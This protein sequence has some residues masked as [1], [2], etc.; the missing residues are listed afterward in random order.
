MGTASHTPVVREHHDHLQ[1]ADSS[2][3]LQR[4]NA[5]SQPLYDGSFC[6][7]ASSA[8]RHTPCECVLVY[9]TPHGRASFTHQDE[10]ERL[11]NRLI[12]VAQ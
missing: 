4:V 9:V 11:K 5:R 10:V 12:V 2:L 6:V 8:V 3:V 7:T 1:P